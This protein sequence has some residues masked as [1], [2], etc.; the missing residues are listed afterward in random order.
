MGLARGSSACS[1]A[2]GILCSVSRAGLAE[3]RQTL[4]LGG[5]DDRHEIVRVSFVTARGGMGTYES[6]WGGEGEHRGKVLAGE[7]VTVHAT[8]VRQHLL[9]SSLY[10][11]LVGEM[12]TV[13]VNLCSCSALAHLQTIIIR[14]VFLG[15]GCWFLF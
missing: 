4:S 3:G 7:S 5:H 12:S 9:N 8:D 14:L 15:R 1:H 11:M 6:R 10:H 2:L 13:V